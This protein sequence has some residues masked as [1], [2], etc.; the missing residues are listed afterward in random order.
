[1]KRYFLSLFLLVSC[2]SYAQ[3]DTAVVL[4][5]SLVL[6][7]VSTDTVFI[8]EE[9]KI[10][11]PGKF[12]LYQDSYYEAVE[13]IQKRINKNNCPKLINGYRVQ[14]FSCSG[15]SCK[16]K[17]DKYYNQVLIAYPDLPVYK[18]WQPPSLKVRVGDCR[19]RFE[20]EAIKKLIEADFP[21]VFIAPDF[22]E[23]PLMLDCDKMV[24]PTKV[25]TEKKK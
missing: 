12:R 21:F 5:D 6:N 9:S 23:T 13:N 11:I 10:V 19:T 15:G 17:A 14:V 8:L 1:M 16:N 2:L 22:I 3:V 4:S 25:D 7:D 24:L 20:A 18:M